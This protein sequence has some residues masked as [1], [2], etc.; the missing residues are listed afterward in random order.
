LIYRRKR[1]REVKKEKK[2]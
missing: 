2:H 1:R